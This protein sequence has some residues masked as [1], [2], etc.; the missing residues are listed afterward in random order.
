MRRLLG[1]LLLAIGLF[2][3]PTSAGAVTMTATLTLSSSSFVQVIDNGGTTGEGPASFT[4]GTNITLTSTNGGASGTV[5]SLA[6]PSITVGPVTY[7]FASEPANSITFTFNAGT[8]QLDFTNSVMVS[9][10]R[11]GA[12]TTTV[13]LTSPLTMTTETTNA[14]SPCGSFGTLPLSG[15]RRS[16]A[17]GNITLIGGSCVPADASVSGVWLTQVKLVGTL[18]QFSAVPEPGTVVLLGAALASFAAWTHRRGRN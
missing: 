12:S 2:V 7:S 17:P 5:N 11:A 15:S 6:F 4:S 3:H 1:T 14:G 8:G 13:A 16:G 18:T 9:V 10:S